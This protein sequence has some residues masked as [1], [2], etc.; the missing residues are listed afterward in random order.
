MNARVLSAA[1]ASWQTPALAAVIADVRPFLV[2]ISAICPSTARVRGETHSASAA[3]LRWSSWRQRAA[4][5]RENGCTKMGRQP[6]GSVADPIVAALGRVPLFAGLSPDDLATLAKVTS[7]RSLDVGT[8]LTTE[9]EVGEEFYVIERGVVTISA[10]EQVAHA[11]PRRLP[12]RDRDPL[13]WHSH[14]DGRRHRGRLAAR[15]PQGRL[16]GEM[17][18]ANTSIEDKILTTASERLRHR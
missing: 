13:R 11:R 8:V 15:A 12:R 7:R 10:R 18:A 3:A 16:P 1:P 9:G 2:S 14:R 4:S 17:L 6:H 5:D